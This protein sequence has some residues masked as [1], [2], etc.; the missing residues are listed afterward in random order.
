MA[1]LT[2]FPLS[3][4][5]IVQYPPSAVGWHYSTDAK[6]DRPFSLGARPRDWN[7]SFE[8]LQAE[9]G[10]LYYSGLRSIGVALR[11]TWSA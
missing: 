11:D 7:I 10:L 5:I 4:P 6:N 2:F 3:E 8:S 9:C 1:Y